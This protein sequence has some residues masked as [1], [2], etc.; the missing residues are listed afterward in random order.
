MWDCYDTRI[1]IYTIKGEKKK[2]EEEKNEDRLFKERFY[3]SFQR[4]FQLPSGVKADKVEA[5]FDKGVL[6]IVLPKKEETK[7]K[8]IEVKVK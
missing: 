8:Q 1:E 7:K 2:E 5:N 4:S 3:G 6:K